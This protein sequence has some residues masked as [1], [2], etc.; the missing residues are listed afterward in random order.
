[1]TTPRTPLI[2]LAL[3]TLLSTTA[4]AQQW[5]GSPPATIATRA[6]VTMQIAP[7]PATWGRTTTA[8]W[9][10]T[11]PATWDRGAHQRA[12]PVDPNAYAFVFGAMPAA[13]PVPSSG[14]S[15]NGGSVQWGGSP[16]SSRSIQPPAPPPARS[17]AQ[18]YLI[19]RSRP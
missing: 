7:M 17:R 19:E 13:R 2:A 8:T 14:G 1:M 9:S 5:G 15:W 12:M 6:T 16:P 11:T 10:G 3:L 4:H 18:Q